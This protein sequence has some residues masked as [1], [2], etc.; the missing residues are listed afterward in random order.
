M[1][2]DTDKESRFERLLEAN[3]RRLAGIARSYAA[4]DEWHDLY[5][6][7][8]L[9]IWRSLDAFQERASVETWVYRIALNTAL[10]H[11]RRA[12]VRPRQV[13]LTDEGVAG[14]HEVV[15]ASGPV[16]ELELLR[17]FI[18]SL[19][20]IDRAVFTLYLDDVSYREMGE[21]LGMSE[22][23]V[24]VR[25]NRIKNAFQARYFSG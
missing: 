22:S 17:G 23:N 19:G 13:N 10:T 16:S 25:I 3:K 9:Q 11:R 6:D 18:G 21:I 4:G 2:R 20:E 1:N 24:G 15:A 14:R 5:Q 8:L 12:A 7:M